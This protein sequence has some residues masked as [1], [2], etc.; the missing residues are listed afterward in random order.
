VDAIRADDPKDGR[1]AEEGM[2]SATTLNRTY[3]A[4]GE[5][6]LLIWWGIVIV[7]DPLTIG[8]GAIGTGLILLGVNA[9]RLLKGIPT[10]ASTTAVGIVALVWGALDQALALRFWPS[11]AAM[12]IVIGVVSIGSLLARPRTE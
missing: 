4:V 9:A 8:M 2:D 12:L 1:L 11:F 6:V 7:V 10:K 3:A 5:G